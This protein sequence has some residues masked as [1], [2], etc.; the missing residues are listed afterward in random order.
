MR[1]FGKGA[2]LFAIMGSMG[3]DITGFSALLKPGQAWV[4]DTV[5]KGTPDANRELVVAGTCDLIFDLWRRVSDKVNREVPEA[6]KAETLDQM[7]AYVLGHLCHIAGDVLSHPWTNDVEWHRGKG[8]RDHFEHQAVEVSHDA[9]VAQTVFRRRSTRSGADWDEWWPESGRVP[10]QLFAAYAEALQ[11]V[12]KEN[13]GRRKGLAQFEKRLTDLDPPAIDA[14]FV[15]SG[16]HLYRHGIVSVGYGFSTGGWV[17]LLLPI[18]IPGALLPLLLAALPHSRQFFQAARPTDDTDRGWFELVAGASAIGTVISL[19]YAIWIATLTTEGIEG[20]T[21]AGFGFNIFSIFF[22]AVFF[23]TAATEDLPAPFRWIVLFG[24]PTAVITTWLT[25]GLIDISEPQELLGLIDADES[26]KSDYGKR[27]VIAF[28]HSAPPIIMLVFALFTR[29][30][31][32]S[33]EAKDWYASPR[34]WVSF[35]LWII[36]LGVVTWLLARFLLRDIKIIEEPEDFPAKTP[37]QV[38]LFDDTTLYAK[39]GVANPTLAD[40]H[41]P[42]GLR[43]LLKL[44][45]TG[46]GNL[47]ARVDGIQIAFRFDKDDASTEQ[48]VPGP[49]GPM[50]LEEYIGFLGRTVKDSSDQTGK[51]KAVLAFPEDKTNQLDYELPSGF[52]FSDHGDADEDT[53]HKE[54]EH[55][56]KAR[57]FQE[58]GKS[59]DDSEYFLQ[60][61]RKPMQAIRFGPSGPV[62]NPFEL[63]EDQVVQEEAENAYDYVHDPTAAEQGNTIMD[64]SAD[65]AALLC[66]GGVSHVGVGDASSKKVHQVFRNW[67]LDRRR[68]NEWRMLVAGGAVSE[69]G[70]HPDKADPAMLQPLNANNWTAPLAKF[71]AGNAA[72]EQKAQEAIAE[73]EAAAL[74]M[75]WV[76]LFREWFDMAKRPDVNTTA[77]ERFKPAN[78]TNRAL[79]RGM[80]FVMDI[81]DPA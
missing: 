78:P 54:G 25:L 7:R 59:E 36:L 57:E 39:S 71:S 17:G 49:V 40:R 34:Y 11:E 67:S 12:Y 44:W 55:D 8:D 4:F 21:S 31:H 61:A 16:Y 28:V 30:L 6:K 46:D 77:T 14:E 66:M 15:A 9:Q 10:K 35:G 1:P 74:T 18:M 69:K 27:S 13:G 73:G 62:A 32:V 79:S 37:H 33:S 64:Y 60:H 29:L 53:R 58:L 68:I 26:R 51:L 75:G 23:G 41:F 52:V 81:E 56:Q 38:R 65:L 42:S 50:R 22:A 63:K 80:A 76:P 70:G 2:S 20:R 24:F 19:G 48:I 43:K 45:W 47:F 72:A 3:P 5:H